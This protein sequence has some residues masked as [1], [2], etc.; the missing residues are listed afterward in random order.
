MIHPFQQSLLHNSQPELVV[1][2]SYPGAPPNT[3]LTQYLSMICEAKARHA[4]L[5]MN[6]ALRDPVTAT[7]PSERTPETIAAIPLSVDIIPKI[8]LN[9]DAPSI[10]PNPSR[11]YSATSH[12]SKTLNNSV[13]LMPPSIRPTNKIEI[14]VVSTVKHEDAY[15]TQ[16]VR[17]A[18]RLPYRSA[19]FPTNT[20]LKA[21]LRKP[22]VKRAATVVS[23]KPRVS[24]YSVYI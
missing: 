24:L 17:H 4:A 20:A 1:N 9:D 6:G 15:R 16:N 12:V 2:K 5:P 14:L 8:L 19:R 3:R 13:A 7:S 11:L 18:I 10:F 22:V 21:A 23:G